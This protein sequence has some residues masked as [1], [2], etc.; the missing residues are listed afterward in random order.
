MSVKLIILDVD[1]T[2]TNGKITYN[3]RGEELKS[4]CVKDGL[5][6]SGWRKL[7]GVVAI[8]TGRESKIVEKRAKELHVNYLYQGIKNKR[9][10]VEQ[11][12]EELSIDWGS[13]AAIGD[14]LNDLPM[15]NLPLRSYA[16]DDANEYVKQKVDT[17][18]HTSGGEGAVREMIEDLL[19]IDG[20]IGEFRAL[21]EQR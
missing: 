2:L 11:I 3:N 10:I 20:K 12:V 9:S 19:R 4:F 13:V 5:G 15:L 7:G 21:W 16:P 6:I 1:G 18:L 17:I 14:D 8:I